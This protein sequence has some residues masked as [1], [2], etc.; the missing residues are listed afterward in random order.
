MTKSNFLKLSYIQR[1][2]LI[3][4][5]IDLAYSEYCKYEDEDRHLNLYD[6]IVANNNALMTEFISLLEKEEVK[7]EI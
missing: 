6:F 7:N 5:H 2:A 1:R 4:N 3:K